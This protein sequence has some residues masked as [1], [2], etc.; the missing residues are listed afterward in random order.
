MTI[1]LGG[2]GGHF[3]GEPGQ[4]RGVAGHHYGLR[5]T[6]S[7]AADLDH[8]G[9][10]NEMVLHPLTAVEASDAGGFDH[11]LE[12]PI[13]CIAEHLGKVPTGPEFVTGRI[14]AAD[15]FE[16]CGFGG[17]GKEWVKKVTSNWWRVT[18]GA[19]FGFWF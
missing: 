7:S 6:L 19:D 4:E 3:V 13:V 17:H 14:G 15:G 11:G 12:I 10:L 8:I 5:R 16:G 18:S 1:H 9:D 2:E